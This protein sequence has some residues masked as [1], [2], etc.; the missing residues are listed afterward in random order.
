MVEASRILADKRTIVIP[1]VI[2]ALTNLVALALVLGP[3]RLRVQ[4][5]TER[6]TTA[7]LGATNA[8][9]ELVEARQTATGSTQA[10]RDLQRFYREILPVDQPS[11]RRV[12]FL[13]LAQLARD[14]NLTYDRR[15]FSQEPVDDGVLTRMDL[16]MSVLGS[17]RDLRR[18]LYALETDES[19]V[20]IRRVSVA[21][22]DDPGEPLEATLALSTYFRSGD[23]R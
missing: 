8:R 12:T 14:A 10:A 5:L 15:A 23:G 6:A 19:F 13:H 11:A 4:T 9:R 22:A 21:R 18:F 20:V 2:V 7:A 1:L 17:Y 16:D 3:L